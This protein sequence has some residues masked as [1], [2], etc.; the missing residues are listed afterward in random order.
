[1]TSTIIYILT[2]VTGFY[3]ACVTGAWMF[4]H[5]VHS[6]GGR[7]SSI[8]PGVHDIVVTFLPIYNTLMAIDYLNGYAR[9]TRSGYNRDRS[10]EPLSTIDKF[11]NIKR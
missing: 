3:L 7:W 9:S 2:L 6:K 8:N 11:F 1:M 4:I 5:T 10:T